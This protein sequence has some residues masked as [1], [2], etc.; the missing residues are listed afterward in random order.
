MGLV[1]EQVV[2]TATPTHVSRWRSEL[3]NLQFTCVRNKLIKL[4]EARAR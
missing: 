4:T 2:D 1:R 3:L